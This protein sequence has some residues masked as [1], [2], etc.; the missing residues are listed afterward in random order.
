MNERM[1]EK[2][3]NADAILVGASNGLSITEGLHLFADNAAFEELFGD[4]KQKYG[5]CWP[6]N[7]MS[8]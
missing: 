7:V 3:K 2:L 5:L 1:I 8:V 6:L 4:L